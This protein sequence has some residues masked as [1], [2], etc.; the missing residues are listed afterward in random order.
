MKPALAPGPADHG[1]TAG[2]SDGPRNRVQPNVPPPTAIRSKSGSVVPGLGRASAASPT[3][4]AEVAR[5][6]GPTVAGDTGAGCH[7]C[8]RSGSTAALHTCALRCHIS[9]TWGVGGAAR[10]PTTQR[11]TGGRASHVALSLLALPWR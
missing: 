3:C 11:R 5:R 7:E 10:M 1:P 2:R 8:W 6:H 9:L 4:P